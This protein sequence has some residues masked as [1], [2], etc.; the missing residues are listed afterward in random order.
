MNAGAWT[1]AHRA[2]QSATTTTVRCQLLQWLC[3]HLYAVVAGTTVDLPC[4]L[5][6]TWSCVCLDSCMH[7]WCVDT[8]P[9]LPAGEDGRG[10]QQRADAYRGR[11][12]D[13]APLHQLQHHDP[14]LRH[15]PQGGHPRAAAHHYQSRGAAQHPPPQ[16]GGQL[17]GLC[18]CRNVVCQ[19]CMC[20]PGCKAP[21]HQA[22]KAG[23]I[24]GAQD[25][26]AKIHVLI[27]QA[28]HERAG[29]QRTAQ[30]RPT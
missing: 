14:H 1:S 12:A 11:Q 24:Y 28:L 21:T 4:A 22:L 30:C 8:A 20:C 9:S 10:S 19:E 13:V 23:C 7:V 26:W 3:V 17:C 18:C 29:S 16:V 2:S 5:G 25:R 6:S 15:L 27:S